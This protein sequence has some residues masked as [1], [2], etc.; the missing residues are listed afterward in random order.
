M[1]RK[2]VLLI[3]DAEESDQAI[4][5]FDQSGREYVKYHIKKFEESCCGEI[6]TTITPSVF[7]PEGIY[8]GLSGVK[9]YLST[10]IKDS[11]FSESAYW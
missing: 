11:E 4:Q 1:K 2:P 8:K 3:D 9:E 10:E 5:I 6:P 7:A